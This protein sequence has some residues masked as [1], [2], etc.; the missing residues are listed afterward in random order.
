MSNIGSPK[1]SR[2]AIY[3]EILYEVS[4][5]YRQDLTPNEQARKSLHVLC[6]TLGIERALY[7]VE[8][9]ATGELRLAEA[10]GLS[11]EERQRGRVLSGQGFIGQ[12]FKGGSPILASVSD[13]S[14]EPLFWKR[15]QP[16]SGQRKYGFLCVPIKNAQR[17]LGVLGVEFE[18]SAGES[19]E[20]LTRLL[21]TLANFWSRLLP[22][23]LPTSTEKRETAP[24]SAKTA[25]LE[26]IGRSPSMRTVLDIARQVAKSKAPVLLRGESGTGK[27]L[28]AQILHS[29][30]RPG[31]GPFVKVVCASIP[32][33]LFES[34]LFG[35]Q[36]GAFT[37]AMR[38]K[39]GLVE[40]AS[41]GTLFLDEIGDVPLTVQIKLLRLLQDRTYE[42]LGSTRT[43]R[44]DARI[45][46][47]TNQ[48]L[49]ELIRRGMFRE[50][51]YYR[52]NV[53]PITLPPLRERRED[54]PLLAAHF[55]ERAN[56]EHGKDV[57][58]TPETIGRL[59]SYLWPGNI[60]EM[61]NLI[62][63]LV[64]LSPG[65]PVRPENLSLPQPAPSRE[66]ER[67]Q[68]H[69]TGDRP[70]SSDLSL[71]RIERDKIVEAL[72]RTGGVQTRAAGLLGLTR[73]QLGYKIRRFGIR[74]TGLTFE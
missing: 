40:A 67:R 2:H 34:E 39:P 43:I 12:T 31:R 38:D 72:V 10:Y 62:E 68:F 66:E 48:P 7:C 16:W 26:I 41:G 6:E 45:V 42:R 23:A 19:V 70:P 53:I 32:E 8:D 28:L 65:G 50:D 71:S 57:T 18:W 69:T 11:A 22:A 63:R 29:V 64:V 56:Q 33:T 73:R 49:E 24:K 15:L 17:V 1:S 37:G 51:L 44:T 20:E 25:T 14:R 3:V 21:Y 60:R 55:L 46:S 36:K 30:G 54:I 4:K 52:L 9:A 35:H 58:L 59:Q 27:E 47:A 13:S 61:E 5:L 74:R